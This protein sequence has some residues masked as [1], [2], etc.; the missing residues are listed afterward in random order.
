MHPKTWRR[1]LAWPQA[2]ASLTLPALLRPAVW[3]PRDDMGQGARPRCENS[4]ILAFNCHHTVRGPCSCVAWTGTRQGNWLC[5]WPGGQGQGCKPGVQGPSVQPK[6]CP[7]A[8]SLDC[9]PPSPKGKFQRRPPCTYPLL[10]LRTPP[11]A[12][13]RP[14]QFLLS[15]PGWVHGVAPLWAQQTLHEGDPRCH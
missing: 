6:C 10:L 12:S 11:P 13:R 9:Q 3:V 15:S 2:P 4:E 7:N 1:H 14:H 8:N 5:L